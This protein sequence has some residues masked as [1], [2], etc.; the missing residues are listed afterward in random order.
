MKKYTKHEEEELI[1]SACLVIGSAVG[2]GLII[3]IALIINWIK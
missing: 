3:A 1:E 2:A